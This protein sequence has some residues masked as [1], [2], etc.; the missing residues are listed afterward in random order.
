MPDLWDWSTVTTYEFRTKRI[1]DR[2]RFRFVRELFDLTMEQVAAFLETRGREIDLI[3]GTDPARTQSV[4]RVTG[5]FR[6]AGEHGVT[7]L[8]DFAETVSTRERAREFIHRAGI[9]LDDLKATLVELDCVILPFQKTLRMLVPKRDTMR[10]RQIRE[11]AGRCG[12][13]P[14]VFKVDVYDVTLRNTLIE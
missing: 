12:Q 4:A 3:F 11:K 7:T 2:F 14:F 10:H 1:Q 6:R 9:T 8:S 5:V 13:K